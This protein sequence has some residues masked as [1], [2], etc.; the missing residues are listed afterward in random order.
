MF[1][2]SVGL[3]QQYCAEDMP[4]SY[5]NSG[6]LEVYGSEASFEN[7]CSTLPVGIMAGR[8]VVASGSELRKIAPALTAHAAGGIFFPDDGFCNP[9]LLARAV[10]ARDEELG[11]RIL[12]STEVLRFEMSSNRV[13]RVETSQGTFSPGV[14]VVSAGIWSQSLLSQIGLNLHMRPGKGYHVDYA[15]E[16][17]TSDVP[18]DIVDRR[19]IVSPFDGVLRLSGTMELTEIG[20]SIRQSRVDAIVQAGQEYVNF[21]ASRPIE[22]WAGLRPMPVDDVPLIG[23]TEVADNVI[24]ATGHS[25]YGVVLAPVTA[26]IVADMATGVSIPGE[27]ASALSPDRFQRMFGRRKARSAKVTMANL[28][29]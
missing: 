12:K 23:P 19:I 14:V 29:D 25:M 6:V 22:T 16:K 2:E 7:G 4:T 1:D 27:L 28:S 15:M 20:N 10:A 18:M 13:T 9:R 21:N 17:A 11:V 5:R 3:H 26:R 8:G 24:V